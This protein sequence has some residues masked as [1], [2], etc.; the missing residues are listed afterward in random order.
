M[1]NADM[2]DFLFNSSRNDHIRMICQRRNFNCVISTNGWNGQKINLP[3]CI[4]CG[5]G[6]LIKNNLCHWFSNPQSNPCEVQI[7]MPKIGI[8]NFFVLWKSNLLD[9]QF[10]LWSLL[11]KY[12]C[13][14]IYSIWKDMS[15]GNQYPFAV[16]LKH[17][18]WS[19]HFF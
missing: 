18:C 12:T 15:L 3:N 13:T 19:L 8:R 9:L 1:K 17:I 16:V 4:K 14:C 10:V 11:L 2:S 5:M 7:E 6:S